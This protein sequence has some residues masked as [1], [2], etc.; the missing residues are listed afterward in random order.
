MCGLRTSSCFGKS[1]IEIGLHVTSGLCVVSNL[2]TAMRRLSHS[3]SSLLEMDGA[4]MPRLNLIRF[5]R[6]AWMALTVHDMGC[7]ALNVQKTVCNHHTEIS[8][9]SQHLFRLYC[10]STEICSF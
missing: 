10:G 1:C 4:D 7:D 2:L 3:N 9:Y 8:H 5:I 6:Y